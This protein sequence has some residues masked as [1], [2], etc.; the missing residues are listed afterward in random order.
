[1]KAYSVQQKAAAWAVHCFTASGVITAFFAIVAVSEGRFIEAFWW[2]LAAL[3]IDGVDGT[4]ARRAKVG[5]VLPQMEGKNIDYVIDFATYAIIPAFLL[6]EAQWEGQYM[7]TENA[8]LRAV[9][10]SAMLLSSALYYGKKQMVSE[11]FYFIGF[12]VLWNLVAFL[13]FA[14]FHLPPWANVGCIFFFSIMHFVPLKYLYPSQT[15]HFQSLNVLVSVLATLGTMGVLW[16][17]EAQEGWFFRI[18]RIFV[19]LGFAY[20]TFMTIYGSFFV[21]KKTH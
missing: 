7:L 21:S 9:A 16:Y 8:T 13:L 17:F 12:P 14:V 15:P 10:A 4:L 3:F 5:A 11:D 19:I 18:S 1:M 2:L 20:F 6:Y